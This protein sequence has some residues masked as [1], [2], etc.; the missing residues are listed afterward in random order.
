M[1]PELKQRSNNAKPPYV[2]TNLPL[3]QHIVKTEKAKICICLQFTA[4][5]LLYTY[6]LILYSWE[7]TALA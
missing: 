4:Q 2:S 6:L 1:K 7:V 5:T 3:H